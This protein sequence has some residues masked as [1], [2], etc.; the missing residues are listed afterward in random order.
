MYG[1][2]STSAEA[3]AA[4]RTGSG[5]GEFRQ[6]DHALYP[7]ADRKIGDCRRMPVTMR[8]DLVQHFA[9]SHRAAMSC[10]IRQQFRQPI[11]AADGQAGCAQCRKG[12]PECR[13][14]SAK[15][16]MRS[17]VVDIS[18]SGHLP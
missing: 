1:T 3:A 4:I 13:V 5:V 6:P 7:G 12:L 10:N 18:E 9:S 11:A 8:R 2:W 15:E 14:A 16:P 17:A